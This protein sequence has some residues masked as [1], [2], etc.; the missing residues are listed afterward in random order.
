MGRAGRCSRNGPYGARGGGRVGDGGSGWR[1]DRDGARSAS[2]AD[3]RGVDRH[4]RP[5]RCPA[6]GWRRQIERRSAVPGTVRGAAAG[7]G[8]GGD[9]GLAVRGRGARAGR[10]RGALAEPAET[11]GLRGPKKRAK[12]DWADAR[13]LREL[14]LIGRLPE[15]WI[16]PGHILDLRARVRLP[17]HA[18]ASADRVAAAD[19]GGALSPRHPAQA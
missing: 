13:H 14:L 3:H 2:G 10:S 4:S 7:G 19:P 17:A 9:D 18:L 8:V 15:S 6:A 5:A 1:A 16:P 12:T 11:S